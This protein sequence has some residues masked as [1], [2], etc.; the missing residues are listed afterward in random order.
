MT[1]PST[2]QKKKFNWTLTALAV[3]ALVPS[4]YGFSGKFYEFITMYRFDADGAFAITPM[5]NYLLAS[6][7]F[8]FLMGW[9]LLHGMFH[10]IEAPKQKMLEIEAWLDQ[11]AETTGGPHDERK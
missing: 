7:G 4:C 6:L 9:A 3:M 11:A 5:L 10:E 1:A 2:E 8:L